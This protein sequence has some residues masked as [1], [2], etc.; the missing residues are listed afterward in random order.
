MSIEIIEQLCR[1]KSSKPDECEDMV[2]TSDRFIAVIDGATSKTAMT[3]NG[4]TGGRLAA[5]L[6]ASYLDAE[7]T[8]TGKNGRETADDIQAMLGEYATRH[9]LEEKGIHLCASAVIYNIARRE[10]W[11]VGDCQFMLNGRLHTFRKKVDTLLAKVRST[12]IRSMLRTGHTEQDLINNDKA[13]EMILGMLRIQQRLE[14]SDDDYGYS[15]FSSH[16][17]VRDVLVTDV[18][19]DSEVVLASDGYPELCPTLTESEERL[20]AL[21]RQDPLCYK[22]FKSTKG[23]TPVATHFDDRSY[24]RFKTKP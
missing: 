24:I 6:I 7:M 13:R 2:V 15:V 20:S 5:D 9:Q 21:M 16:G 14:N 8:N 1:S 23:L 22:L 17:A 11:S 12:L 3:F 4:K 10:I 18:P 19:A